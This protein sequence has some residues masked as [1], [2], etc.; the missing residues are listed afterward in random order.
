MLTDY[1]WEKTSHTISHLI[2]R[3]NP[4][5]ASDA[6]NDAGGQFF[7]HGAE[8][9]D[10]TAQG[11]EYLIPEAALSDLLPDLFDGIHL[12]RIGWNKGQ[13]DPIWNFQ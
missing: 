9:I 2:H 5:P 3:H 8:A 1:A 6:L 11:F 10:D 7:Y 12:R 4:L 13:C